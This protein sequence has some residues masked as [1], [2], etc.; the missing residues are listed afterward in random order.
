MKGLF[1]VIS[2]VD[3]CVLELFRNAFMLTKVLVISHLACYNTPLC[4]S[5]LLCTALCNGPS[6]SQ[7]PP[8]SGSLFSIVKFN[9]VHTYRLTTGR[10][11]TNQLQKPVDNLSTATL[12]PLLH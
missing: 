3:P 6:T 7:T 10:A 9:L 2:P 12:V 8:S 5:G 4:S 1:M 11:A